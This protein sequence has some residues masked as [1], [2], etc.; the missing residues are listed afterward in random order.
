[1]YPDIYVPEEGWKD[2]NINSALIVYA[3]EYVHLSDRKK[4]G[5]F[6]FNMSY[7]M[8]QIFAVT[9]VLAFWYS[10]WFLLFLGFLAPLPSPGRAF[11]EF[12]GYRMSMAVAYWMGY[13]VKPSNYIQQFT[14]SGYYWMFPFKSV[15]ESVLESEL[16]K[17]ESGVLS[18]ELKEI[19]DVLYV[20]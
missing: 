4:W 13:K 12:R 16:C 2:K 14:K 18:P 7:L 8:P 10:N 20:E 3:H 5:A 9:A 6:I 1:M 15:V 19:Y 11:I 17:I